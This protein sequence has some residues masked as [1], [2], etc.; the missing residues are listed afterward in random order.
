MHPVRG[1]A[2]KRHLTVETV[3]WTSESWSALR[4]YIFAS[5][6]LV[7][8]GAWMYSVGPALTISLVASVAG[9]LTAWRQY[10]RGTDYASAG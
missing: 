1:G 9:T 5:C 3:P 4:S 10:S 2:G 8:I 7:T 6:H